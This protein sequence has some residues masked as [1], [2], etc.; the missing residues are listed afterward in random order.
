MPRYRILVAGWLLALTATAAAAQTFPSKSILIVVPFA[1]GGSGDAIA[2]TLASGLGTRLGVSVVIENKGGAGGTLG[3]I[4]VAKSPPDGHTLGIGA[5]GAMTIGPQFPDAPPFDGLRE[6]APVARLV[7]APLVIVANPA[8]GLKSIADVIARAK[9]LPDGLTY[10]STGPRSGQHLAVDFIRYSAG[11]KLVHVSYRGSAPAA[12]DVIGGQIPLA[13]IDLTSV[14]ALI[15]DGRLTP[16]AVTS[17]KRSALAPAI[18][19]LLES[20]VE[21]ATTGWLGLFAPAA[22]PAPLVREISGHVKEILA[23]PELMKQVNTQAMGLY[24]E[25]ETT[26][27]T[28]LIAEFA[29]W[30]EIV[31]Q[32]GDVK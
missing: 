30:K 15:E 31:K 29:R 3:L 18:P 2:R 28:A 6:L 4:Q 22:T 17:A 5:A 12:A 7:E 1:A 21:F 24:Y 10:G 26:F 13:S 32:L 9:A 20:G 19:T 23:K 16:L 14:H 27:K 25:D 8:S 11:V